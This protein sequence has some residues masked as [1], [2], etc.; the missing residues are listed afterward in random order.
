ML[1]RIK[2]THRVWAA[3]AMYWLVFLAAMVTGF[4]GMKQASEALKHVHGD[5]MAVAGSLAV[6]NRN[7]FD[8]RLQILLA[9]QHDP[10]SPLFAIHGHA[11]DMHFDTISS[12]RADNDAAFKTVMDRP[13]GAAEKALVDDMQA[14]RKAWQEKRD[15]V[16]K[17]LKGADFS[18]ET[19]N[20]FLVAGRTEGDAFEKSIT[21]LRAYQS[22]MADAEAQAA[23]ARYDRAKLI[24]VGIVLLGAIPMT[25]LMLLTLKRMSMG[26]AQADETATSIAS[27]DLSH[28]IEPTGADEITHLLEQ[29]NTMQNNL[30]KLI[31]QVIRGADSIAS[32]S[33]QVAAG[34]LD[35]SART[36]QQASSLEETASATEELNSTVKL[37]AENATQAN[38]MAESA[39]SVATKGGD[40]VAQVVHTMD[41]INTSSRKIVDIIAVIDGIAFQTNILALNAAVEAARAGEQGRGF[42]VVASEVRSLAQRSSTAAREIKGLIDDSV[43]K[44]DS[45][46]RQVDEAGET[47]K[48]IVSSIERVTQ[49]MRDIASSSSE[50]ALGISQ[51]N[52]AVALMDGVTQQN[53]ALV[54][55]ASA[56]SAS[57]QEQAKQLTHV[58]SA[59]KL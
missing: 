3:L 47:M 22:E 25:L 29:M 52:Q 2:L 14:K 58:V 5:R 26:F 42:A 49:I 56:A 44:V 8:N 21:K 41:E 48:E 37:N 16:L 4:T 17:A 51:I 38:R 28:R 30:R 54:E 12:G 32:A 15:A 33:G 1:D 11:V 40:V 27:G 19:M 45:G 10:T 39:S 20:V 7:F 18:P 50:Q 55:E 31:A 9:F 53:A 6:I 23:D 35:L 34:T 13:M 36:E 57:L 46:T 43:N 24:F 59:F